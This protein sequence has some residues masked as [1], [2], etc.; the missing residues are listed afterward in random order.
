MTKYTIKKWNKVE[1][2]EFLINW[3]KY[4]ILDFSFLLSV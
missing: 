1:K 3:A 2:P 4:L